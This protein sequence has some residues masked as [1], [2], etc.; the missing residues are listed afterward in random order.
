MKKRL[1]LASVA[2]A[3]T[4]SIFA[5]NEGDYAYTQTQRLKITGANLVEEASRTSIQGWMNVDG[6][7][8]DAATWVNEPA[9]GPA[10][11]DAIMS[12]GRTQDAALTLVVPVETAGQYLVSYS[13]KTAV[14]SEGSTTIGTTVADNYASIFLNTDGARAQGSTNV[15][16]I[17]AS[18]TMAAEWNTYNYMV[19]TA[20]TVAQF[21]V[22]HFER[23]PQNTMITNFTVQPV[24]EVYDIRIVERQIAFV[25]LLLDDENFNTADAEGAR[26]ELADNII[27][28]I[29]EMI[30]NNQL[31]DPAS[32]E[33]IIP[34]FEDAMVAYLD[35]SSVNLADY[36]PSLDIVGHASQS[37][38]KLSGSDLSVSGNWGHLGGAD[39]YM[40]AIQNSYDHTAKFSLYNINL[41][42]GKYF[43]SA[44]MRNANTN[45]TSWPCEPT[46][47]AETT[48]QMWA[49]ND[50]IDVGPI[51]G[52]DYQRF[53]VIGNVAEDGKVDLGVYWPGVGKGGAFYLRNLMARSFDF[54]VISKAD[55]IIAY[56]AYK[57][58][59]DAA[60]SSRNQ[61]LYAIG[62][63]NYPWGQTILTEERDLLDPY[64][65]A[66]EAK[67]WLT[68]DGAD[69]GIATT[70]EF[71]DWAL[72]QGIEWYSEP[73][74]LG[75][76]TKLEYQLVR[77]YQNTY[78]NVVALNKPFTDFATAI[79]EA[80]RVRNLE[81]NSTCDRE[82][83]KVAILEA[84]QTI[85]NIREHTTDM[86]R[87]ADSTKLADAQAKLAAATEV[88]LASGE[89]KPF[90]EID[91]SN[92]PYENTETGFWEI[93]GT[94]GQMVVENF[95]NE[96]NDV[97]TTFA[98]GYQD[99]LTDV[100]RVGGGSAYVTI[101]GNEEVA[102]GRALN[103]DESYLPSETECIQFEFDMWYGNLIGKFAGVDLLNADGK[104]VA[105]FYMNRY[106]GTVEYNDFN[107]NQAS[108]A[109]TGMDILKYV[110]GVGSSSSSNGA[111]CVDNNKSH[112]TLVVN[113]AQNTVMGTVT[114]GK[115]G[116]CAGAAMPISTNNIGEEGSTQVCKF[117]L[118]SNYNNKDRRCWFDN[119]KISKFSGVA[120]E[121]DITD[122][123]WAEWIDNGIQTVN[124]ER[125]TVAEGIYNLQGVRVNGNLSTLRPGLYIVNGKKVMIK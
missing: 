68:A 34:A 59:W 37:R 64:Y 28:Y 5:Y 16:Q 24:N 90:F 30:A 123:P 54:D 107:D 83:Y 111:I 120:A 76:T 8:I 98:L 96:N 53:Y 84:L 88:F 58:Q 124:A 43:F 93:A 79:D 19:T 55:H 81:A 91:F 13:I 52:V 56:K 32:A 69:A 94:S 67:G 15:T 101:G 89:V 33:G 95:N 46:F 51:K 39:Y 92:T 75:N 27:P 38:G 113:R 44:E 20:D 41:P 70:D 109:G 12:N 50:T 122:T 1:L 36:L 115:N 23:L 31:D 125:A 57:T 108:G 7:A 110:S 112:F 74:S 85:K 26:S 116:T 42:A 9:V 60:V 100:L 80:K 61:M 17:S 87:V 104:R 99:A 29:E 14:E 102:A 18:E 48:C 6:D 78:K 117:V 47:N 82:T 71:N 103:I 97:A 62:Q 49:G 63:P 10:G 11:E 35:A 4:S 3:F 73:D 106:D 119:L 21:V 121:E 77:G 40:S 45:K 86:T 2:V 105:G 65:F 72:Y 25:K 22:F 118:K 114:N 66:Q